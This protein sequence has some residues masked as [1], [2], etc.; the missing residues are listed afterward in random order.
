MAAK[1]PDK[2]DAVATRP[3]D[4]IADDR[5]LSSSSTPNPGQ[6]SDTLARASN[7]GHLVSPSTRCPNLPLG[8][9]VA[10]TA[11]LVVAGTDTYPIPGSDKLGVGKSALNRISKAVGISWDERASHRTDDGKDPHF[12]SYKAV[13]EYRDFDGTFRTI[14]GEKQ[15]DLREGSEFAK[16]MKAGEL[17]MARKFIAEHAQTKA[18][19]RAIRSLGIQTSYTATELRKPFVCARLVFSGRVDD[20][21]I[22]KVFAAETARAMLGGKN[23]MYGTRPELPPMEMGSESEGGA[24]TQTEGTAGENGSGQGVAA[25]TSPATTEGQQT[26]ETTPQ[27][28]KVPFGKYE[29]KAINDPEVTEGALGGMVDYCLMASEDKAN[30]ARKDEING[31][32]KEV[33][34]EIER[35]KPATTSGVQY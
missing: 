35:R 23:A 22:Q 8:C 34:A 14:I 17:S 32:L 16:S 11:V 26:S 7:E 9:E 20:P 24:A 13:G 18:Q 33:H 29:G 6:V 27:G 31:W 25:G 15:M 5:G 10:F 2:T 1:E 21:E 3:L 12:A 19:L 4:N 30:A 28:W